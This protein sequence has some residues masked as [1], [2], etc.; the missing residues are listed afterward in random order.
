MTPR[1]SRP[2]PAV[3]QSYAWC[4]WHNQFSSTCRLVGIVEQGSGAGGGLFACSGCREAHGLVPVA[5]QP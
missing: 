1:N 4:S 3:P 2:A 5:D